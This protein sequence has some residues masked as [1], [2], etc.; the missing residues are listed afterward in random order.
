MTPGLGRVHWTAADYR[1]AGEAETDRLYPDL[2]PGERKQFV[3]CYVALNCP[4]E[5]RR[6]AIVARNAEF[7]TG[8]PDWAR[9]G[10][11]R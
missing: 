3:D 11:A 5:K 2:R 4:A 9:M 1:R 7:E 10:R 8:R 6:A